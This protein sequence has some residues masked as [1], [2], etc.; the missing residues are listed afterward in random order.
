MYSGKDHV[1][2]KSEQHV[3]FQIIYMKKKVHNNHIHHSAQKKANA[4]EENISKNN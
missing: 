4:N 3:T 2:S 1:F